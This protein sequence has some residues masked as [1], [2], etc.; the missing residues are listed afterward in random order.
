MGS[1]TLILLAGIF[2]FTLGALY[3]KWEAGRKRAQR[4]LYESLAGRLGL[5]LSTGSNLAGLPT[6][7]ELSGVYRGREVSVRSAIEHSEDL[8]EQ[9]RLFKQLSGSRGPKLRQVPEG[10][11]TW[12]EVSCAN[13]SNL[14]FY[15][16]FRPSGGQGG[17]EFEG[18]FIVKFSE[19]SEDRGRLVLTE[20]LRRE[21]LSTVTGQWLHSFET[22]TMVGRS[23]LY[24]ESGRIKRPEQAERFARM[25]ENLCEVADRVEATARPASSVSG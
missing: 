1:L 13:P 10:E 18:K 5:T 6:L 23:L 8:N 24:I 14:A 21:L 3:F 11:F 9:A 4:S 22:L 17:T 2:F 12:I 19:G 20:E 16:I 15:V 7:P 25:L